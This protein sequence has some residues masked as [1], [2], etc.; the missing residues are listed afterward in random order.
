MYIINYMI[1]AGQFIFGLLIGSFLNVLIDRIPSGRSFIRGR[2][3]CDKCKHLLSPFDLV[4][5]LSYI[6][7]SGKC[8]YCRRKISRQYALVELAAA[9]LF[10]FVYLQMP[11]I[12]TVYPWVFSVIFH[13]MIVSGLLVIFAT[14][15]KYRIIPDGILLLLIIITVIMRIYQFP[16]LLF[17]NYF[18]TGAVFFILFLVLFLGTGGKGMGFGDVKYA[19]FMGLILG[20][21]KIIVGFYVAFLTG[22]FISLILLMLGKKKMKSTV[23]FGPF[24]ALA[25]F[26]ALFFGDKLWVI[27]RRLLGI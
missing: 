27:F 10:V 6:L 26:I 16:N 3:H 1:I 15:I 23:P 7:L 4:P 8:R 17:F 22:A 21:P 25:T 2:S 12:S 13:L 24:L 14:D 19:F 5:V 20:F 9:I 18:L 11:Y